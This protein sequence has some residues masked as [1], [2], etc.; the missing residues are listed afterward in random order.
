MAEN[1]VMTPLNDFED[2]FY[3]EE[4]EGVKRI[5]ESE[6]KS[7]KT[8]DDFLALFR[9]TNKE[10]VRGNKQRNKMILSKLG[11]DFFY[12]EEKEDKKISP[13]DCF[14]IK[15]V[16]IGKKDE[17]VDRA[18]FNGLVVAKAKDDDRLFIQNFGYGAFTGKTNKSGSMAQTPDTTQVVKSRYWV[19]ESILIGGAIGLLLGM[20]IMT[21]I[22][23]FTTF[24]DFIKGQKEEKP[25]EEEL[26]IES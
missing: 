20:V 9:I 18:A 1:F 11:G 25:Q 15:N 19:I 10:E 8:I 4:G 14:V 17:D 22:G 24:F 3:I 23:Y 7:R 5:E 26:N 6:L 12:G 21:A 13:E 2:V 16:F